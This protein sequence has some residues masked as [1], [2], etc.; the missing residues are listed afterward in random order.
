VAAGDS[1]RTVAVGA[2]TRQYKIHVP[3]LTQPPR[4]G[5]PLVIYLHGGG[6]NMQS[7]FD[8]HVDRT[9]DKFGFIL[10][11]PQGLNRSWN[12]GTWLTGSC[13]G[14]ADDVG[15]IARM[16]DDIAR[17]FPLDQARVY[18]MG[19]SNGGLMTNRLACDLSSRIAAIATVAPAAIESPC[20][21][22]VPVPVMDIHG[23]GDRCNP[24]FGGEPPLALCANVPY[25][26]MTP[27]EV[28]ATWLELNRC[29]ARDPALVYSKGAANCVAFLPCGRADVEFCQVEGMGHT[30]PSG[31]QY[32]P[33]S[34]VGPVSF[35]ISTDQ[36][37]D[38]FAR[39]P[40]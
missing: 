10:A 18:A 17:D 6:G 22:S 2:V 16:I 31:D 5:I 4:A 8:D 24:Y 38:F 29:V 40:K 34:A 3:A 12:G 25:V 20:L 30:W 27:R 7:A 35:D 19:I 28:V 36:I 26:R 15:F 21:P 33:A 32:L 1:V 37:W 14:D 23:T 13:C 39:H 11:A 9:A